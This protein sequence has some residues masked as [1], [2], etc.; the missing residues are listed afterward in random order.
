MVHWCVVTPWKFLS[1]ESGLDSK[2][3]PQEEEVNMT[4][5]NSSNTLRHNARGERKPVSC[6]V[7]DETNVRARGAKA[8]LAR[9]GNVRRKTQEQ[10]KKIEEKPH[11]LVRRRSTAVPIISGFQD[12]R[13][14]QLTE[15][16]GHRISRKSSRR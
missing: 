10:R 1:A 7:K 15:E 12:G 14:K 5:V 4:A 8:C 6:L 9:D 13:M 11:T 3:K 2:R 16:R